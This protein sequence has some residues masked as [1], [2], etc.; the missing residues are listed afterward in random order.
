MEMDNLFELESPYDL[1]REVQ[2][3]INE[4]DNEPNN[5][6]LLFLLFSLNHLREWIAGIGYQELRNKNKR[7]HELSEAEKFCLELDDLNEFKVVRSMCNRSKHHKITCGDK[8]SV[9]VGATC[10]SWCSDSLGQKYY[11]IN[12]IDSRVILF[13][14]IREYF[15]WFERQQITSEQ[16]KL[17]SK[18]E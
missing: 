13:T 7:G 3:A 1:F 12:D 9:T 18:H 6:L 5:R 16:T 17:R 8:T 10:N 15:L 4:Y 2:A 14:V 11:W